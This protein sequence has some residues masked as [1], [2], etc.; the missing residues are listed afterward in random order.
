MS[1]IYLTLI[2]ILAYYDTKLIKAEKKKNAELS[3]KLE[4]SQ[5]KCKRLT[6]MLYIKRDSKK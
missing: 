1:F 5:M 2:L 4:V 3:R 6:E